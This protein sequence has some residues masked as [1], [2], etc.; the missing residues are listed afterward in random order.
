MLNGK[1]VDLGNGFG[2][3]PQ[4]V[5]EKIVMDENLIDLPERYIWEVNHKTEVFKKTLLKVKKNISTFLHVPEGYVVHLFCGKA[6]QNFVMVPFNFYDGESCPVYVKSGKW[7]SMA[8][9]D[10][11]SLVPIDVVDYKKID[12]SYINSLRLKKYSYLHYCSNETVDGIQLNDLFLGVKKRVVDMSSDFLSQKINFKKLLLGYAHTTK[13]LGVSGI[14][15][16]IYD[17]SILNADRKVP[18]NLQYP[19]QQ[20]VNLYEHIPYVLLRIIDLMLEWYI[21]K[22][23]SIRILDDRN[24]R[25]IVPLLRVLNEFE[26]HQRSCL[27]SN[28]NVTVVFQLKCLDQKAGLLIQLKREGFVGVEDDMH[29]PMVRFHFKN[30]ATCDDVER[31][32]QLVY[33]YLHK[34]L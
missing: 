30:T 6:R 5:N 32:S 9:D 12:V 17:P 29:S 11:R 2:V 4:C 1:I 13:S 31:L 3:Y 19:Y 24:R 33:H 8:I 14:C 20:D 21:D 34:V 18:S 25:R 10:A 27:C 26:V 16:A 15:V 23:G 28:S 7:S 22:F